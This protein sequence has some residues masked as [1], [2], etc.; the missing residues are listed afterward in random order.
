MNSMTIGNQSTDYKVGDR[1]WY[2]SIQRGGIWQPATV[3]KILDA[4]LEIKM[5]NSILEI[6]V[7]QPKTELAPLIA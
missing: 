5:D 3:I 4:G 7:W 1:V 6:K 2:Y